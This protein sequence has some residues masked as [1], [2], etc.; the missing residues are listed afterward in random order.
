MYAWQP[1]VK[2]GWLPSLHQ[3][4]SAELLASS[5]TKWYRV[6]EAHQY[7]LCTQLITKLIQYTLL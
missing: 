1:K 7:K 4:N 5:T 6:T 3:M 2:L